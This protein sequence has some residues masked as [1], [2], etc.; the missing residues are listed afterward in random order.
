MT[1]GI[2]Y[3]ITDKDTNEVYIGSTTMSINKR[4]ISHRSMCKSY[5]EGKKKGGCSSFN[6]IRRN[7]YTVKILEN[8]E[9]E[10]KEELYFKERN[11]I[12]TLNAINTMKRPKITKEEKK[13]K[14]DEIK[15]NYKE[16][17]KAYSKKY[18]KEYR[19]K[20][21]EYIAAKTKEYREKNKEMLKEK[22]KNYRETNTERIKDKK[23]VEYEKAKQDGKCDIVQCGCGGT[24]I[25]RSKA[26][27]FATNLHQQF[28]KKNNNYNI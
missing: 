11:Y 27:H 14:N 5:D 19:A 7:N 22:S 4:M 15:E 17:R 16:Q 24:Y 23:K 25:F 9:Y 12:E 10:K 8:I 3:T 18:D 21:K 6:I 1:I 28:I 13:L 26:R 20:N 2:I